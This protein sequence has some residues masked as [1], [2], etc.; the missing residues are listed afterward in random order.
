MVEE[1]GGGEKKIVN[2]AAENG[3]PEAN[4]VAENTEEVR[5]AEVNVEEEELVK[6]KK[7]AKYRQTESLSGRFSPNEVERIE[8]YAKHFGVPSSKMI[9]DSIMSALVSWE[10][11]MNIGKK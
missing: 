10:S 7:E 3:I 8:A 2:V 1:L 4:V 6:N 9:R 11:S 5:P